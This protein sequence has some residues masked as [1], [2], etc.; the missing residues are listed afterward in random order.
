MKGN[1]SKMKPL[2]LSQMST[3]DLLEIMPEKE[4]AEWEFKDARIFDPANFGTFKSQQLGKIVSSF[5]N[6]GGGFLVLGKRDEEPGFDPVPELQGRTTLE[7]HLSIVLSQSVTPHF[8]DFK[9]FRVPISGTT[10]SVLVVEFSDSLAAPYQ[11]NSHV[12]YFYRL[13][14]HAKEA[15]HFHLELLRSRTTRAAVKVAAVERFGEHRSADDHWQYVNFTL[16]VQVENVSLQA[17][18]VWGVQVQTARTD[19]CWS[20]RD[21]SD[22]MKVGEPDRPLT[23]GVT[24][25]GDQD[26][27][28]PNETGQVDIAIRGHGRNG[29]ELHPG[30]LSDLLSEFEVTLVPVSQNYAGEPYSYGIPLQNRYRM[31]R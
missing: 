11:S 12:T 18:T 16:R 14:G 29:R 24:F 17:A 13:P 3:E 21:P 7:D 5:A 26:T 1:P 15:P 8:R 27:L 4:T 28:L 23:N 19:Y 31:F 2:D 22:R 25:R 20:T 9:I 10:G 30:M 6:S